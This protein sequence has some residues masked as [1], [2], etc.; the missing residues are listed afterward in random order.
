MVDPV[1]LQKIDSLS[2]CI[3]RIEK[4]RPQSLL[5][6][7]QDIDLQDIIAINLE[8][9]VQQCVDIAMYLLSDGDQ[10]VPSSMGE[11]FEDL[12]RSGI[13]DEDVNM[14]MKKAVGFRNAVVHAYR[15]IDWS[16][17]WDIVTNR[18]NDFREFAKQV[19]E[20]RM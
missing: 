15:K 16:I 12:H 11:A 17:V 10:P 2:R 13:I 6:L 3:A 4:K 19:I 8:R 14:H 20:K 9:A 5:D 1:I 7:E 18:L